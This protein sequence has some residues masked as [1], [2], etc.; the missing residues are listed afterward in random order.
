MI[1]DQYGSFQVQS[2]AMLSILESLKANTDKKYFLIIGDVGSGKTTM[3]KHIN[4]VMFNNAS[5]QVY[6]ETTVP[7]HNLSSAIVCTTKESA[8]EV[9]KKFVLQKTHIIEIPNLSD[10]KAD[11]ANF[12]HFFVEVLSLMNSQ[13][14]CRLTEKAVEKLLHYNWPGNF[15]ELEAVLEKAF[16]NCQAA[17]QVAKSVA[18]SIAIIEPAHIDLH[19]QAKQLEFSIGQKLDEVERK[20]ILQTL[21][22]VQQNRTKAADILGISIR[23]LR[24]KINQYREEGYL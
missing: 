17:E 21:Y 8:H 1:D 10:R 19:L 16:E 7:D 2:P 23:T 15:H 13:R 9:I 11:V 6:D 5:E 18:N 4:K 3:L 24:N 20:Y 14:S 12:S 22:F